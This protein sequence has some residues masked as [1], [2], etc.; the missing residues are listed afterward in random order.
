MTTIDLRTFESRYDESGKH[1]SSCG[2]RTLLD[3]GPGVFGDD[4]THEF[5][6]SCSPLCP[7][8]SWAAFDPGRDL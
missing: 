6:I 8:S 4:G 1:C 7:E 3:V 2:K 5:C